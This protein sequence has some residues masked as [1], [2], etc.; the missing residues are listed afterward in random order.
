MQI[1]LQ[2][3]FKNPEKTAYK[4]SPDGNHISWLADFE[5]R[6]NIYIQ[7]TTG[8]ESKRLTSITERDLRSYFW[9]NDFQLA[10]F[11]D[12]NGDEN[13]HFHV[14]DIINAEVKDLTP[15]ENVKVEL[16]DE[17]EDNENE[18]LIMM[19]KRNSELFDV[20]KLK[21]DTGEIILI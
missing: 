12:N 14:V 3:F 15:F 8:G 7:K 9:L 20:Y 18:V 21:T 16:V 13:D 1:P 19:N 2:H 4:I 17:L 11:K 6:L 5:G 10:F